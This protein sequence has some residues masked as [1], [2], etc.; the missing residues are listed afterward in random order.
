MKTYLI[1]PPV[2]FFSLLL[3]SAGATAPSTSP[4]VAPD[5]K[6][7]AGSSV[8]PESSLK[9]AMPADLIR[10]I[11]G[12]PSAIRPMKAPDGKAEIWVYTREINER[13]GREQIGT[14]PIMISVADSDGRIRQ[15]TVGEETHYGD[16]HYITVETVELLMFNDQYVTQKVSR[17]EMKRL[18]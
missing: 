3:Q 13:M 11:M 12:K 4:N 14:T 1:F 7:T 5:S 9:Q 17:R 2:L 10:K 16:V 18:G 8:N 6:P 15:Y